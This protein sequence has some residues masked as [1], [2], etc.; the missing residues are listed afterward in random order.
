MFSIFFIGFFIFKLKV[1]LQFGLLLK[2]CGDGRILFSALKTHS[3]YDYSIPNHIIGV[4]LDPHLASYCRSHI[5]SFVAPSL[6]SS[7]NNISISN[8]VN[9]PTTPTVEIIE[10]DM[11]TL[12]LNSLG[13]NHHSATVLILYLLPQGL[14]KLKSSLTQ[15]LLNDDD[16]TTTTK[17][18]ITSNDTTAA[19][20][21]HRENRQ[22]NL[23]ESN[24]KISSSKRIVTITYSIPEWEP[25]KAIEIKVKGKVTTWLFYWDKKS[26]R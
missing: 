26:I 15:W 4:E 23:K 18:T 25:S 17:S 21:N 16:T 3:N 1:I 19:I 13:S 10:A 14:E 2:G 7:S 22:D 12:N 9:N 24:R 20:A 8:D 5:P 6:S 11:F